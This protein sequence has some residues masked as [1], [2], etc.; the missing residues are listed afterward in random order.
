[1]EILCRDT[2]LRSEDL[3]VVMKDRVCDKPLDDI[4]SRHKQSYIT[5]YKF[6]YNLFGNALQGES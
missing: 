5:Y 4:H 6:S 3:E 2:G 1:M